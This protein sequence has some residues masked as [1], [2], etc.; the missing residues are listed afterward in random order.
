MEHRHGIDSSFGLGQ[1]SVEYEGDAILLII[2]LL[3]GRVGSGTVWKG[4][5]GEGGLL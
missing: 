4:D 5:D 3:T 1:L 2:G